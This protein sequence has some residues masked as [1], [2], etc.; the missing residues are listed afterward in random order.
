MNII[1]Y[2][3]FNHLIKKMEVNYMDIEIFP[4]RLLSVETTEKLLID[5][6]RIDAVNRMVLHGRRLSPEETG[7][8]EP[9][10][11][12]I[13]DEKI[14]LHVKTGRVLIEINEEEIISLD[15]LND[16]IHEIC[17]NHLPFGFNLTEGTF[18][19]KEKTVTDAL[20]YGEGLKHLP[21]EMV[22]LTDQNAQLSERAR[23]IKK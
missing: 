5:L 20:K 2:L 14:D 8:E 3:G 19:R 7:S 15:Q 6:E 23:I 9:R 1:H 12:T 11:I 22:G 4:H 18:I 13:R 10:F 16:E 17:T 21:N